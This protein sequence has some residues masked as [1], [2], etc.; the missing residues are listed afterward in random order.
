[1]HPDTLSLAQY[2]KEE[3][4]SVGRYIPLSL[5]SRL[6]ESLR[7][8]VRLL[9][10]VEEWGPEF[11]VSHQSVELCRVAFGLN[12]PLICTADSPHALA[13]NRLTLPLACVVV[14]SEAIPRMVWQ[15]FGVQ[16][17]VSFRGVDEV[18]W[19]KGFTPTSV[20]LGVEV[21]KPLIIV[22]QM[23]ARASYAC[24][25]VDMTLQL[26]SKLSRLG[27]VVF[28]SRYQ[29]RLG[30]KFIIPRGFVD[31]ASLVAAADLVVS[32]GGTIAREAALQGVPSIVVSVFPDLYVNGYLSQLGFPLWTV[33]AEEV[34]DYA[35][36]HVG[37]K[38]NV[39]RLVEG[40]ENP[41]D[42][43]VKILREYKKS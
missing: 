14:A 8:Q 6:R 23:E 28:L 2:L 39:R 30:G 13:V 7:R 33:K 35:V 9:G 11:A 38:W 29:K 36:K 26:A 34:M 10:I 41:V 24:G 32:A 43:I 27:Q 19:I 1:M 4:V 37:E 5:D 42:V 25:R 31:S 22:R 21:K 18:A 40:L 15:S 3:F 16:K 17:L 20:D 12:I